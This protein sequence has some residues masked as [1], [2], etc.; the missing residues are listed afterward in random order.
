[1]QKSA[2]AVVDRV[3]SMNIVSFDGVDTGNVKKLTLQARIAE[4]GL[5]GTTEEFTK[6]IDKIAKD[7]TL[8][9]RSALEM[10]KTLERI[11]GN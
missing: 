10:A 8:G 11:F 2:R 6:A 4:I 3:D 1:M 7:E 9:I 5:Q